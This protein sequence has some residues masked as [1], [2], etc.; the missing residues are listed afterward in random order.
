MSNSSAKVSK[1]S[2]AVPVNYLVIGGGG[3]GTPNTPHTGGGGAGGFL[4]GSSFLLPGSTYTIVV[5]TGGNGT[6]YGMGNYSLFNSIMAYGGGNGGGGAG[7]SGGGAHTG[8]GYGMTIGQ[9]YRGG[10]SIPPGAYCGGGGGGAGGEG[11]FGSGNGGN[12]G[13]GRSSSITGTNTT[14]AGGGGGGTTS[15]GGGSGGSGGGGQ[16][17]AGYG[18]GTNQTSGAANTGSGGG[19]AGT[20]GTSGNGGSGVVIIAYLDTYPAI[21]SII[22]L[23]YDQPARS[24]YRVYRFTSGSGTITL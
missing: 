18:G 1:L 19:G 22:G 8:P 7:A 9:G 23:T 21:S 24:G 16:G 3:A 10:A 13:P 11:G 6:A 5:G 15:G 20:Q 17:G 2:T 14:Y 4:E 12:G